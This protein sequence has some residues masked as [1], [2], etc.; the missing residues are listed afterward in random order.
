MDSFNG[1]TKMKMEEVVDMDLVRREGAVVVAE[2]Q[3]GIMV[4]RPLVVFYLLPCVNRE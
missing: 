3:E 2:A 4:G 1:L